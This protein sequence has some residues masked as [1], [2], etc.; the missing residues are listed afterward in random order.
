MPPMPLEAD[1]PPDLLTPL[2]ARPAASASMAR[3]S[4]SAVDG[5]LRIEQIEIGKIARQ[6]RRIGEADIFV[7]GRDARHRHRALGEFR[8][9]VAADVV[10][11]DH[12]LALCRPARAIR[13]RRLRNARIPR[14]AR[15]ALRR[16]AIRRA[17]PPR[18][19]RQRRR[20]GRPRP[21]AAPASR[22]RIGRTDR[23]SRLS[24]KAAKRW[25]VK[26]SRTKSLTIAAGWNANQQPHQMCLI[27]RDFKHFAAGKA[28]QFRRLRKVSSIMCAKVLSIMR[29]NAGPVTAG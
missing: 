13:R 24:T 14:R 5:T 19:R 28:K 21:G 3:R 29:A 17:P 2:T 16:P 7:V 22:V 4:S 9:A 11:R 1:A 20:A 27:H 23:R 10:G 15:R 26:S 18:R 6:Q 12:R 25:M 8:N